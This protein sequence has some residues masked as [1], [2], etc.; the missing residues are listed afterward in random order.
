MQVHAAAQDGVGVQPQHR[1]DGG[2]LNPLL[3]RLQV[4]ERGCRFQREVG[5]TGRF[6]AFGYVNA[7]VDPVVQAAVRQAF[8][9]VRQM[10][11]ERQTAGVAD[12]ADFPAPGQRLQ[13]LGGRQ[14]NQGIAH[15]M[16]ERLGVG[17]LRR[18][19]FV[20]DVAQNRGAGI[21]EALHVVGIVFQVFQG[22]L[23]GLRQHAARLLPRRGEIDLGRLFRKVPAERQ[24]VAGG[25]PAEAGEVVSQL[26]PDLSVG[27]RI[28]AVNGRADLEIRFRQGGEGRM[29]LQIPLPVRHPLGQGVAGRLLHEGS[30]GSKEGRGGCG[31]GALPGFPRARPTARGVP[32]TGVAAE[33]GLARTNASALS[34]LAPAARRQPL[35][36][37]QPASHVG[38]G[39]SAAHG[40]HGMQGALGH[41]RGHRR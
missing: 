5:R 19:Q 31:G 4:V 6:V 11:E 3:Q 1:L 18:Q 32:L 17:G 22:Q 29:L 14:Q 10:A 7:G 21:A 37:S 39:Q 20:H 23:A 16:Q 35:T 28:L 27:G 30:G 8:A 38:L 36:P 33:N 40:W 25:L 26:S 34:A 12:G 9:Q 15:L 24:E 41:G 2:E 13:A